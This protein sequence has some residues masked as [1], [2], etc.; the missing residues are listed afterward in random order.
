MCLLSLE[1]TMAKNP[2]MEEVLVGLTRRYV[3]LDVVVPIVSFG[4]M[5][6]RC[7]NGLV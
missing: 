7:A 1:D 4:A 2:Q 6:V 5:A 3:I